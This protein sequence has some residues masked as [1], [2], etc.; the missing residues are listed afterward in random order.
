MYTSTSSLYGFEV[1]TTVGI[2]AQWIP[3]AT[4][5]GNSVPVDFV[6]EY[7]GFD[8]LL[9]CSVRAGELKTKTRWNAYRQSVF[10][11]VWAGMHDALRCSGWSEEDAAREIAAISRM[12]L[13]P[14]G[15]RK[16]I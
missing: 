2:T 13:S 10:E 14:P 15:E 8:D 6:D 5:F 9:Y 16:I 3:Y 11:G 1:E 4:V 12:M 7:S